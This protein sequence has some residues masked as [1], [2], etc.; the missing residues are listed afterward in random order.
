MK[1]EFPVT[2]VIHQKKVDGTEIKCE[3]CL[4]IATRAIKSN[5]VESWE[6]DF[7]GEDNKYHSYAFDKHN[8]EVIA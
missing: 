3:G 7:M 1:I 6:V 5:T 4:G 2:V 8:L